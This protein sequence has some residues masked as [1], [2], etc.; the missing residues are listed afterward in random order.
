VKKKSDNER[1]EVD[2]HVRIQLNKT[3][4]LFQL[5]NNIRVTQKIKKTEKVKGSKKG[6]NLNEKKQKQ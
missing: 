2:R 4:S 3:R 6:T 1:S 5:N